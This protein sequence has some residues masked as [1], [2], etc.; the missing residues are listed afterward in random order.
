MLSCEYAVL[1]LTSGVQVAFSLLGIWTD[2][3][4]TR[5]GR[6]RITGRAGNMQVVQ[7]AKGHDVIEKIGV[8]SY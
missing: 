8:D 7:N 3:R 1:G 6:C 5:Q 2:S 4:T